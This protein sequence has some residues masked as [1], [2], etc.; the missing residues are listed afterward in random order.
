MA[1]WWSTLL[2]LSFLTGGKHCNRFNLSHNPPAKECSIDNRSLSWIDIS[3]CR[4][5]QRNAR[6]RTLLKD[7]GNREITAGNSFCKTEIK[8]RRITGQVP[9]RKTI[10]QISECKFHSHIQLLPIVI[11]APA[12]LWPKE[13]FKSGH[14][15]CVM[16]W[17][18]RYW[19]KSQFSWTR[20]TKDQRNA[21]KGYM[22]RSQRIYDT[23]DRVFL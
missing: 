16:W 12:G 19:K 11:I 13:V 22:I 9:T 1:N 17:R 23:L 5:P 7:S 14:V 2:C 4:L 20:P 10:Y 3:P 8:I 6:K 18:E 21:C 15:F